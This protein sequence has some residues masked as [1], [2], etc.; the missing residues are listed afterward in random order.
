MR[1]MLHVMAHTYEAPTE[2]LA[3][4][5]MPRSLYVRKFYMAVLYSCMCSIFWT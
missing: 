1:P 2:R 4:S 5:T 3:Y